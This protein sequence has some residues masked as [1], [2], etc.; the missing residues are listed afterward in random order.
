MNHICLVDSAL[1]EFASIITCGVLFF[2]LRF[3]SRRF[4]YFYVSDTMCTNGNLFLLLSNRYKNKIYSLI[5]NQLF[6]DRFFDTLWLFDVADESCAATTIQRHVVDP[7][8]HQ[9]SP[10]VFIS[11]GVICVSQIVYRQ[12]SF[13]SFLATKPMALYIENSSYL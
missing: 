13:S 9:I 4:N 11:V 2:F 7:T 6:S 1:I 5:I 10:L 3:H 8:E 12:L